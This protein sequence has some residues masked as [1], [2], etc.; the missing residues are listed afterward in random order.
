MTTLN[1][2]ANDASNMQRSAHTILLAILFVSFSARASVTDG[3]MLDIGSFL[4]GGSLVRIC[5]SA[6]ELPWMPVQFDHDDA[7][8]DQMDRM[9][10]P[11]SAL[12]AP[13]Q[14]VDLEFLPKDFGPASKTS[15]LAA[16]LRMLRILRATAR[17]PP[18]I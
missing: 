4:N 9:K 1:L 13:I 2:H 6:G 14:L 7:T 11:Y 16:T 17:G 8:M 3:M 5:A 10:C 15:E 12:D 18:S